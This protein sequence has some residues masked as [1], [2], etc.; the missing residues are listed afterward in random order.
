MSYLRALAEKTGGSFT[1]PR[2][3][4]QASEEIDRMK[5]RKATSGSDRRR[6]TRQVR[7]DMATGRGDG[8]RVRDEELAGYGSDAHWAGG[9]DEDAEAGR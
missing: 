4:R 3:S 6:E 8:A 9:T 7:R 2:T 5:G 1:Y